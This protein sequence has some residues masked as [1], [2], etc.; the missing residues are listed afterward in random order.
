MVRI[1]AT[2]V[3]LFF[4][5]AGAGTIAETPFAGAQPAPSMEKILNRMDADRDGQVTRQE[6]LGHPMKFLSADAN[7]D[8]I[9]TKDEL[10]TH[11]GS[12]SAPDW[13]HAYPKS[14][15]AAPAGENAG[16]MGA[17]PL[18]TGHYIDT[19]V[20]PTPGGP[21]GTLRPENM[22][23]AVMAAKAAL[24]KKGFERAVL[25]PTP[26]ILDKHLKKLVPMELIVMAAKPFPEQFVYMGG[27]GS[28]NSMIH[29]ESPNG[30]VSDALKAKF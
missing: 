17:S 5:F 13:P 3:L 22:R 2:L 16:K 8:K 26:H 29:N 27:G 28:L 15:G 30:E 14:A 11:F 12:Q 1:K 4:A 10:L 21:K 7:G 23:N 19:H 18:K 20:H 9:L 6:W 25:M 24:G